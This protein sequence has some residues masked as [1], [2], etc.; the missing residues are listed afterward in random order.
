[1]NMTM[2]DSAYPTASL[3]RRLAAMLYDSLL[4]IALLMV[5]GLPPVIIFGGADSAFITGPLY[6]LYLY[7]IGFLFFSWFWIRGGQTLGMRSWKLQVVCDNGHPLGWQ[8][9]LFRYLTATV[10]LCLFGL[11]FFSILFNKQRLAWH[12]LL[13]KTRIIINPD[14]GRK[15][16]KSPD[17]PIRND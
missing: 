15:P 13:S 14:V 6:K 4:L 3:L 2:N 5:A 12:D 10:S 16:P 1:M 17:Y 9:A 7:I 8:Q 11:G